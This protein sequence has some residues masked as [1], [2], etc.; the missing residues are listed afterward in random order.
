M[1][2]KDLKILEKL[3]TGDHTGFKELFDQY[4]IPLSLYSLKYCNDYEL[5]KDISQDIFVKFWDE[6][7]YLKLNGSIGPYLFKAVKNNTLQAINKKSK[8]R[9]EKIE[10]HVNLLMNDETID[11]ETVE[12]ER[13]KL[14]KEIENLP[15]KSKEVFK[16]IVLDNLKYKKVAELLSITVNTVKTHHSRTLKQLR[17]SL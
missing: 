2:S 9:F 8:Y 14:Y 6:K 12:K 3:K 11:L 7:I 17:K 5:P 15:E 13:N 16:A 10:N 4:Y 1:N